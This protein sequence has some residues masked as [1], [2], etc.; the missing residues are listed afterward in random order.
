MNKYNERVYGCIGLQSA[1]ILPILYEEYC[2]HL[3][4]FRGGR[5]KIRDFELHRIWK[6]A[7]KK[8]NLVLVFCNF[9]EV[10][11]LSFTDR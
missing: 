5:R 7:W 1:C 2:I 6:R 3:S 4:L 9:S 10:R 8:G 11:S